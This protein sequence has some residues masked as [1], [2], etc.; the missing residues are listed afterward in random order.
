[1]LAIVKQYRNLFI[2]CLNSSLTPDWANG[3]LASAI[4]SRD[5]NNR[6]PLPTGMQ[7]RLE[8]FL[9]FHRD[10]ALRGSRVQKSTIQKFEAS[11]D[12]NTARILSKLQ[13]IQNSPDV[14]ERGLA[15]FFADWFSIN[16]DTRSALVGA[17]TEIWREVEQGLKQVSFFISKFNKVE[18]GILNG[19]EWI[20]WMLWEL[21]DPQVNRLARELGVNPQT[22]E[23]QAMAEKMWINRG[24]NLK[25]G[26]IRF[27]TIAAISLL[28]TKWTS[29]AITLFWLN[30]A[31]TKIRWPQVD[32]IL[33]ILQVR[34]TNLN[35]KYR[36][37]LLSPNTTQEDIIAVFRVLNNPEMI[38]SNVLRSSRKILWIWGQFD[39]LGLWE[40]L[41]RVFDRDY[42]RIRTLLEKIQDDNVP[43]HIA[44]AHMKEIYAICL[45]QFRAKTRH[46]EE[47]ETDLRLQGRAWYEWRKMEGGTYTF[48][49]KAERTAVLS[50]LGQMQ[51]ILAEIGM[52]VSRI[53]RLRAKSDKVGGRRFDWELYN[54][55]ARWIDA[56]LRGQLSEAP[57]PYKIKSLP[58][59]RLRS[60]ESYAPAL[61]RSI[62]P[63]SMR[64]QLIAMYG[65]S[66]EWDKWISI[67]ANVMRW[68]KFHY[69][70]E[71]DAVE[72]SKAFMNARVVDR[73]SVHILSNTWRQKNEQFNPDTIRNSTRIIEIN[74]NGTKVYFA[75]ECVNVLTVYNDLI[76]TVDMSKSAPIAIWA[77][78]PGGPGWRVPWQPRTRPWDD[79]TVITDTG[80]TTGTTTGTTT[81]W[82]VN[83]GNPF[84]L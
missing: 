18:N 3:D 65:T 6:N 73:K 11:G 53:V 84:A 74:L 77:N 44:E 47:I 1:M 34:D 70:I 27:L 29:I 55:E 69:W 78:I 75:D 37:M 51:S 14:Q 67:L 36:K 33:R 2:L 82:T 58:T 57:Y 32:E 63:E 28:L 56:E 79:S 12:I 66:I 43:L 23:F 20:I 81:G 62:T 83:P 45:E 39:I 5:L 4:E 22:P 71:F 30:V 60:P 50:E 80:G 64:A 9:A 13:N 31:S 59:N 16:R 41:S 24:R 8:K 26:A 40:L 21:T 48:Y 35:A 17:R 68:I 49:T 61:P 19:R 15:N 76:T 10:G 38:P 54:R 25:E 72:F 42:A 52:D 7:A 46:L